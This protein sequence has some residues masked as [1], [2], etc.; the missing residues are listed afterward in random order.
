MDFDQAV[1][2]GSDQERT[3]RKT[4]LREV[5]DAI[6]HMRDT[7][8][9]WW[10]LPPCFPPSATVRQYFHLWRRD[11]NFARMMDRL[12]ALGRELAGRSATQT[13]AAI[14]TQSAETT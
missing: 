11:G 6:Q 5:S 3:P 8:C 14:N 4:D 7:G 9:Q 12:R 13:A 2:S 1:P 10:A